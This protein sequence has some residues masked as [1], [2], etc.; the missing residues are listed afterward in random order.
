MHSRTKR[1][2][3]IVG[4]VSLVIAAAVAVIIGVL[5]GTDAL[6]GGKAK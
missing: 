2:L 3:L 5:V 6:S 1:I 4:V